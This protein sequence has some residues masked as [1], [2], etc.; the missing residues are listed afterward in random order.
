MD[1]KTSEISWYTFTIREELEVIWCL[2]LGDHEFACHTFVDQTF[3][4]LQK[5]NPTDDNNIV[6]RCYG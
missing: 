2:L 6:S 3:R 5:Q 4:F 1:N